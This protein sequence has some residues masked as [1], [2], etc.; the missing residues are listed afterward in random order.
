MRQ[1]GLIMK[2]TSVGFLVELSIIS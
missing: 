1:L 2:I